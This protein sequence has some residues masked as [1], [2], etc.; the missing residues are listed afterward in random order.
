MHEAGSAKPFPSASTRTQR[1][2]R[3]G[4]ATTLPMEMIATFNHVRRCPLTHSSIWIS[5]SVAILSNFQFVRYRFSVLILL[6]LHTTV[7]WVLHQAGSH[8]HSRSETTAC[9]V[10]AP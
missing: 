9:G 8:S 2:S 5:H 6:R 10:C 4:A 1:V 3:G 7:R